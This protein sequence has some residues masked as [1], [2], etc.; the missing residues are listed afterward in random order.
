MEGSII[1]SELL[2]KFTT[3]A[4]D[5]GL[6]H[7]ARNLYKFNY[8]QKTI[9]EFRVLKASFLSKVGRFILYLNAIEGQF[10]FL[11]SCFPF[12]M[13]KKFHIKGVGVAFVYLSI[14]P[15]NSSRAV[16]KNLRILVCRSSLLHHTTRWW[17]YSRALNGFFK[18]Y[19]LLDLTYKASQNLHKVANK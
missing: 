16:V 2:M 5:T 6:C 19:L 4:C 3:L 17:V 8:F 1:V 15:Q 11:K 14:T 13:E 7:L 18:I 10:F 9:I 12:F